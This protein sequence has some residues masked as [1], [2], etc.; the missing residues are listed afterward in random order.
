MLLLRRGAAQASHSSEREPIRLYSAATKPSTLPI[1]CRRR[2]CPE[3]LSVPFGS[4]IIEDDRRRVGPNDRP[5]GRPMV[6]VHR[7]SSVI[8]IHRRP[9]LFAVLVM[10]ARPITSLE[11]HRHC[12]YAPTPLP[13]VDR[14]IDLPRRLLDSNH[15]IDSCRSYSAALPTPRT[16][17]DRG[18][19]SESILGVRLDRSFSCAFV[20]RFSRSSRRRV[21]TP[22]LD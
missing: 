14:R 21:V 1:I 3:P 20:G 19:A 6:H 16:Q 18:P 2:C 5:G 9:H 22:R 17:S 13:A 15:R 12:N 8:R 11:L 4:P 7:A 10:L